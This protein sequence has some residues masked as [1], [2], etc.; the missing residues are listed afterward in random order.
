MLEKL[1]DV[2]LFVFLFLEK[3]LHLLAVAWALFVYVGF[4]DADAYLRHVAHVRGLSQPIPHVRASQ[5][6]LPGPD[7]SAPVVL[8]ADLNSHRILYAHNETLKV[9][10]ASTTKLMTALV[11]SELYSRDDVLSVPAQCLTFPPYTNPL[12]FMSGETFAVSDLMNAMLIASSNESA[13]ILANGRMSQEDFVAR[14]N[15][16]GQQLQMTST[17]FTNPV[18]F[19][20]VENAHFSTA[21][22]LY[23][24]VLKFKT[25]PWLSSICSK[26]SYTLFTGNYPRTIH[27]TNYMFQLEPNTVGIK[28]GTTPQAGEVLIF[29]TRSDVRDLLMIVMHSADRFADTLRLLDWFSSYYSWY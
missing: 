24:L 27:S 18:G 10:P 22:D 12:H 15:D 17:H 3:R 28:T 25:H 29:E 19:D 14:M 11:A 6:F 21:L 23:K 1:T 5:I 26:E 7:I 4:V 9:A 8:V 2:L 13:C 20:S 16:F